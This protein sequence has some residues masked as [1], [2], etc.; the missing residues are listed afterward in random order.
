MLGP[1]LA[2]GWVTASVDCVV[3]PAHLSMNRDVKRWSCQL[4]PI[5]FRRTTGKPSHLH[6]FICVCVCVCMCVV[7]QNCND[8]DSII[9]LFRIVIFIMYYL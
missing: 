7:E 4:S 1:E 9:V 6:S 2:L 8:D 5:K 3:H